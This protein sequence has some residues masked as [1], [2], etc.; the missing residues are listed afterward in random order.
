VTADGKTELV[1]AIFGKVLGIDP[2]KG[3]QLWSCATDIPWYMVPSAVAHDGVVYCIG[4]RD[5]GGRLAVSI[6]GRGD[7]TRQNR[8]WAA[9]KGSNVASPIYHDGHL[10]WMNDVLGIAYCAEAKT[11]NILYEERLPR[12]GQVYA[13]P[14]LAEGRVH[15]TTRDGRTYV[16]A[17]K[18]TFELLATNDLSD[19]S[20]FNASPA[21]AGGK[22]LI[23]SDKY[24]YCLGKK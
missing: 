2:A 21:V 17:A 5:G 20:M 4:G 3:T 19:R 7:V 13:S 11:G 8:L 1:V 14:V 18:P 16:V 23:R 22:L 10:Y 6:G 12:A 24:L 9:K 15:Y